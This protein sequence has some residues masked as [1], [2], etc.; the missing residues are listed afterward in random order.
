MDN[1]GISIGGRTDLILLENFLTGSSY[2]DQILGPVVIPVLPTYAVVIAFYCTLFIKLGSG[3]L[4]QHRVGVEQERCTTS[5]WANLLFINNYVNTDKIC[6]FQSWFITCDMN[7]FIFS[8]VLTWFLWQKPKLGLTLVF[9]LI[10]SSII[11]VFTKVYIDNLDAMYMIYLKALKDPVSHATFKT[12]YI[13]GHMRASSYFIGTLAGY[14]KFQIKENDHKISRNY[15]KIGWIFSIPTMIISLATGYI[16]YLYDVHQLLT[17]LYAAL[18]HPLWS[19][20]IAWIIIVLSLGHEPLIN[21]FLSWR[22]LTILAK[23]SFCVYISHGIIQ[24]YTAGSIR[25]PTHVSIFN[26]GYKTVADIVLGYTLAFILSMVYESP[27]IA[28]EKLL[29]QKG[30][31]PPKKENTEKQNNNIDLSTEIVTEIL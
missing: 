19:I 9:S 21:S 28:L 25:T 29:L 22:P 18:Y 16:F 10:I 12:L 3:P 11:V 15:V 26:L 24:M 23:L 1:N 7:F 14:Y 27:V 5:W 8:P 4:W 17:A 6:M 30:S 2:V 20:C 31:M 13:P